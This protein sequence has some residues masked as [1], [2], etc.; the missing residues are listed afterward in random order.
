MN[1]F[2]GLGLPPPTENIVDLRCPQCSWHGQIVMRPLSDTHC[3]KCGEWA[4][5]FLEGK[6]ISD[7]Y[8]LLGLGSGNSLPLCTRYDEEGANSRV[9]RCWV[10]AIGLLGGYD[11]ARPLIGEIVQLHDH[12]GAL[13]IVTRHCGGF[14]TA[15]I[16]GVVLDAIQR[17]WEE[18]G[19]E[20]WDS[21]GVTFYGSAVW[22]CEFGERQ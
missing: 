15:L 18:I 21:V 3:P 7:R 5:V 13:L 20:M 19:C 22:Q 17:A 14:D 4:D 9:M 16:H 2:Q 6:R 11:K 12:K 10:Y 1:G 8:E